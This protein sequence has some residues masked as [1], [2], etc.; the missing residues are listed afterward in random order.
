MGIGKRVFPATPYMPMLVLVMNI[1]L[2]LW[3]F[4]M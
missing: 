2:P 4:N 1:G 3:L